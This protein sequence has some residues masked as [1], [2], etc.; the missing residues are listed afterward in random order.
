MTSP[1][2][3]NLLILGF[4]YC[5]SEVARQATALGIRCK[6]TQREVRSSIDGVDVIAFDARELSAEFL[7]ALN[8]ADA[9]LCTLPPDDDG[10]PA[11]RALQGHIANAA[12]LRWIGYLSSTGVYANRDG[13]IIDEGSEADATDAVATRRLLAEKQWCTIANERDIASAVFRLAG[14]YGPHRNAIKSLQEGSARKVHAPGVLFNRVH[15]HDI[16]RAVIAAMQRPQRNALYLIAD[17]EAAEQSRVLEYAAEITGLNL[18]K[19]MSLDDPEMTEGLRRFYESSKRIN[20]H[21]SWQAL[22]I[23]PH[24]ANYREGLN[25]IKSNG[26]T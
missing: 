8:N 13:G 10:D 22:G 2:P 26:Q 15:V 6:A 17:N 25:E 7:T 14:I 12:N 21:A 23:Q 11:A 3:K 4:G 24:F 5:G 1:L 9:V 20:A 16:A 18:P 19:P